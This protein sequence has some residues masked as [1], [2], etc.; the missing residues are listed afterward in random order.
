MALP[1]LAAVWMMTMEWLLPKVLRFPSSPPSYLLENCLTECVHQ[2]L[3][4]TSEGDIF[5]PPMSS[6]CKAV[7]SSQQ[8]R[9]LPAESRSSIAQA[10]LLQRQSP[11]WQ[12][13]GD[14][15]TLACQQELQ[16]QPPGDIC[17][18]VKGLWVQESIPIDLVQDFQD[19]GHFPSL[20][21]FLMYVGISVDPLFV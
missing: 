18:G 20:F 2:H 5:L 1:V 10:R 4:L 6:T 9:L 13:T 3:S 17:V 19:L 14:G 8:R 7:Q 11:C 21:A 12:A 15:E 16:I